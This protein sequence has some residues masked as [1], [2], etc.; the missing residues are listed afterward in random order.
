[1]RLCSHGKVSLDSIH[2][3]E[4]KAVDKITAEKLLQHYDLRLGLS[5]PDD[6]NANSSLLNNVNDLSQAPSLMTW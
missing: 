4:I 3:G 1:M 5:V 6:N 2:K